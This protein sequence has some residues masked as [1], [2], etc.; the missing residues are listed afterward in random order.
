MEVKNQREWAL[1]D[2]EGIRRDKRTQTQTWGGCLFQF[3]L[4]PSTQSIFLNNWVRKQSQ[5]MVSPLILAL[6]ILY[7]AL[8]HS[9]IWFTESVLLIF[10]AKDIRDQLR[11]HARFFFSL[12]LLVIPESCR[13]HCCICLSFH[14]CDL[15]AGWA[16][17]LIS[18]LFLDDYRGDISSGLWSLWHQPI[19]IICDN[20]FS[21]N[22]LTLQTVL[23]LQIDGTT[24]KTKLFLNVCSWTNL[25]VFCRGS[26]SPSETLQS[27]KSGHYFRTQWNIQLWIETIFIIR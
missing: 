5:G 23:Y 25:T 24:Y 14:T 18:L 4:R 9:P 7:T 2:P 27:V 1:A 15:D 21:I 8:G 19:I 17:L 11:C 26:L 10:Q 12:V 22:S 16:P 6:L 3:L 13:Q 20:S